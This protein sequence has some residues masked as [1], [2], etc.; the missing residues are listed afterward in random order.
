MQHMAFYE[1]RV[2]TKTVVYHHVPQGPIIK[3]SQI[4]LLYNCRLDHAIPP[5]YPH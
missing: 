5:Y 3:Q 1:N 4:I 2:P